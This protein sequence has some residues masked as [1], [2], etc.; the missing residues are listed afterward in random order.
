MLSVKFSF[1]Y[2]KCHYALCR[3]AECHGA[4]LNNK[5]WHNIP[6]IQY[7]EIIGFLLRFIENGFWVKNKK[8]LTRHYIREGTFKY[9]ILAL[10]PT[11]LVINY[12]IST[13]M[14][15]PWPIRTE[16]TCRHSVWME[17]LNGELLAMETLAESASIP[18]VK[19]PKTKRRIQT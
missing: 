18:A 19:M 7:W 1:C 8:R 11:D 15:I 12:F 9:D 17:N 4:N 2:A 10:A 13:E 3:Y 14:F 6:K 16:R 5:L